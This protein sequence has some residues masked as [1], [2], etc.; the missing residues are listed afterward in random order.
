M[1]NSSLYE[2]DDTRSSRQGAPAATDD[3]KPTPGPADTPIEP[4]IADDRGSDL[5]P[6]MPIRSPYSSWG[7]FYPGV[8]WIH[9][10]TWSITAS[11]HFFRPPPVRARR[12]PT[13]VPTGGAGS[14]LGGVQP[15]P[16]RVA[17]VAFHVLRA[18]NALD[19][20]GWVIRGDAPR[21]PRMNVVVISPDARLERQSGVGVGLASRVVL[22][23]T[24]AL[25]TACC[26]H[27][28]SVVA[29][30]IRPLDDDRSIRA[31]GV[32]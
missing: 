18:G 13:N 32:R 5:V 29:S 11:C 28:R 6:F 21:W 25:G 2:V 15:Q 17:S 30:L 14:R 8:A 27:A 4:R 22:S 20:D 3:L 1:E 23:P 31:T 10:V 12:P 7:G 9:H 19:R 24:A 26:S 16:P